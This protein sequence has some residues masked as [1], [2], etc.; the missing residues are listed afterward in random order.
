MTLGA[1]GDVP[2]DEDAFRGLIGYNDVV[3]LTEL[4]K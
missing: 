3:F 4:L 2:L 1:N